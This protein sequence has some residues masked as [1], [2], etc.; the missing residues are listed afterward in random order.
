MLSLPGDVDEGVSARAQKLDPKTLRRHGYLRRKELE[1]YFQGDPITLMRHIGETQRTA[2]SRTIDTSRY[3]STD[4]GGQVI[5][6]TQPAALDKWE[7]Q[8]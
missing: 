6:A 4:F 2:E 5:L 3:I 8:A 1:K 7:R